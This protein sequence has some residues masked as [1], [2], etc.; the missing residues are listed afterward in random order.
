MTH[1]SLASFFVVVF[2]GRSS[3]ALDSDPLLGDRFRSKGFSGLQQ[4]ITC[5]CDQCQARWYR[6][7]RIQMG[8]VF[9]TQTI[10]YQTL[11]PRLRQQGMENRLMSLHSQP[12][13]EV[14]QRA[15][16]GQMIIQSQIQK[17]SI[18]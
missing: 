8:S 2:V 6:D 1:A 18:R 3:N 4:A 17:P 9:N 5:L 12:L 16:I 11:L 7:I 13:P 14:S 15:D 10:F